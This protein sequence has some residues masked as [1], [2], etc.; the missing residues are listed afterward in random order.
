MFEQKFNNEMKRLKLKRY[1]VC[2]LLSCTRP[3]LKTRLKDPMTFTISEIIILQNN[4]FLLSGISE[5][6]NI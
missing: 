2:T 4:N 3:T 5:N 1:E 6:L